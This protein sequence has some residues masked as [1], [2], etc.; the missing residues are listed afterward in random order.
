MFNGTNM[1]QRIKRTVQLIILA[2]SFISANRHRPEYCS[3]SFEV[4]RFSGYSR[5]CEMLFQ[6]SQR[7][8]RWDGH[9]LENHE[10][11]TRVEKQTTYLVFQ[12]EIQSETV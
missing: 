9:K 11:D 6:L 12:N 5:A 7:Q 4:S 8:E 2:S 10:N 3:V 1:I